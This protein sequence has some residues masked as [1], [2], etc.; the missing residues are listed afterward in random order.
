MLKM[1]IVLLCRDT[2]YRRD[3][4]ASYIMHLAWLT[5]AISLCMMPLHLYTMPHQQTSY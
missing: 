4:E 2:A 1:Y 5:A 3:D